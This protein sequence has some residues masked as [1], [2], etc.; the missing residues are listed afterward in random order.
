VSGQCSHAISGKQNT[1]DKL[2]IDIYLIY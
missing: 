2:I 1:P